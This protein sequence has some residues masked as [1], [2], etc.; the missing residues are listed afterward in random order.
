MSVWELLFTEH[1]RLVLASIFGSA[2][3]VALD[4]TGIVPAIR[5]FVTGSIIGYFCYELAVPLTNLFLG[6]FSTNKDP[7]IALSG[8]LMGV[9]GV[10][11]IETL[12]LG[13]KKIGGKIK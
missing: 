1:G 13:I 10:V 4:W 8:F 3:A 11:F 12:L 9:M 7:S 2:V 5:R 6:V